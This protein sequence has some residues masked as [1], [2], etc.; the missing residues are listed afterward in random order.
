MESGAL[1]TDLLIMALVVLTTPLL[2][3]CWVFAIRRFSRTN[4]WL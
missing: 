4:F 2:A 3:F 1:V